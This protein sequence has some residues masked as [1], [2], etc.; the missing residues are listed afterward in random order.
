MGHGWIES[1]RE[2]RVELVVLVW[3]GRHAYVCLCLLMFA[4]TGMQFSAAQPW[5][6]EWTSKL[7]ES[8]RFHKVTA[9]KWA[10]AG[11]CYVCWVCPEEKLLRPGAR[12]GG[13]AFLFHELDE[14]GK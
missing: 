11:A 5:C 14:D 10:A 7:V 6:S 4:S 1:D 12:H 9:Q 13:F 3:Y 8:R 2:M